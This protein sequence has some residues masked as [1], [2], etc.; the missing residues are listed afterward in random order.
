MLDWNEPAIEFYKR[1]NTDLD[2]EWIN[3]RLE[4]ESLTAQNN[5]FSLQITA[6]QYP[7]HQAT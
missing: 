6:Q 7:H 4:G 2:I 1:L 3:C 5:E